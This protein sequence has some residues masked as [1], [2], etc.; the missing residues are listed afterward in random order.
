MGDWQAPQDTDLDGKHT[1]QGPFSLK[2]LSWPKFKNL[3]LEGSQAFSRS[4]TE[5]SMGSWASR[6][7][8]LLHVRNISLTSLAHR[9]DHEELLTTVL[10]VHFQFPQA[11]SQPWGFLM[12]CLRRRKLP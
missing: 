5:S 12:A 6:I 9:E 11:H 2:G 10:T 7:Q 3:G 4:L 1:A 8:R